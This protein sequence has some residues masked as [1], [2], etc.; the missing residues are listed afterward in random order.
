MNQSANQ[1]LL[2]D[3]TEND[4]PIWRLR[5]LMGDEPVEVNVCEN[6]DRGHLIF[7]EDGWRPVRPEIIVS[8]NDATGGTPALP[9]RP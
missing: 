4:N 9:S 1:N 5:L 3:S 7:V 2:P 6:P 8:T